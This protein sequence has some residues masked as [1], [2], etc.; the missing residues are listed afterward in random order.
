MKI[1]IESGPVTADLTITVVYS[2]TLLINDF[3]SVPLN[4]SILMICK[5]W[6]LWYIRLHRTSIGWK[7][8]KYFIRVVIQRN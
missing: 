5:S 7:V 4:L 8:L 2:Y 6:Q 1:R 3:K